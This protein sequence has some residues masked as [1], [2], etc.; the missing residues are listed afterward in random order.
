M[1][2]STIRLT[3]LELEAS[4]RHPA[5]LHWCPRPVEDYPITAC[6]LN[7]D[8]PKALAWTRERNLEDYSKRPYEQWPKPCPVCLPKA[9]AVSKG[10]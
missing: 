10:N 2:D 4:S 8:K 1:A 7:I 6:G 3:M 5:Y 9:Q